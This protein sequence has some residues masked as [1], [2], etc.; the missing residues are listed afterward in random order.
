MAKV[1]INFRKLRGNLSRREI[2]NQSFGRV[3]GRKIEIEVRRDIGAGKSSVKGEGRFQSYLGP[4]LGRG[5]RG[6]TKKSVEKSFYPGSVKS[7]FPNKKNRPVNLRLSGSYLKKLTNRT[8]AGLVELGFL[9]LDKVTRGK[10]ETH[11]L[12]EHPHVPKRKHLPTEK[13]DK[14]TPRINRL[15]KN[16]YTQRIKSIIRR[17]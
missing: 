13:G 9:N 2:V 10:F 17:G 14:F 12:G 8:F 16:L 6:R 4:S 1:F 3:L 5:L 7:K 11:N 15:I